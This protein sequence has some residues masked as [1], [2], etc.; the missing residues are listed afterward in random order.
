MWYVI[1]TMSGHE[2]ELIKEIYQMVDPGI[3]ERCFLLK[4]EAVWRIQGKCRIHEETL[5]PGYVFV[6]SEYPQ[7][8]YQEMMR[9]PGF[10]KL[11]GKEEFQF[12][13]VSEEEEQFL[14]QLLDGDKENTI[15]LSPVKVNE[16]KEIIWCG[17]ALRHFRDKI[18]K[19]RIRLRYVLIRI[20]LFGREREVLLGIWLEGDLIRRTSFDEV[21]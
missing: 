18:V 20:E 4:R 6:Q 16:E 19:K 5:F 9:V 1:Q 11:L 2:Q 10:S 7:E 14:R 8:F 3:Y 13:P 17:G 15:R 12:Y 21:S